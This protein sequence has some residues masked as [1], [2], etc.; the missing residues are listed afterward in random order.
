MHFRGF[1]SRDWEGGR[2]IALRMAY[3]LGSIVRT[4][5]TD[6]NT[7]DHAAINVLENGHW[8]RLLVE[9]AAPIAKTQS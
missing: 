8:R 9:F 2:W 1:T 6:R 4:T 5:T 7:K 3:D